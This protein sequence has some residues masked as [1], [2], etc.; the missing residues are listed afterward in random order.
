MALILTHLSPSPPIPS[1][2]LSPLSSRLNNLAMI[3]SPNS[4]RTARTTL[5]PPLML[6]KNRNY[7]IRSQL[8]YPIISPDDHWGT[9]T[10]LF[11]TGAFG[12]WYWLCF[13]HIY[14]FECVCVRLCVWFGGKGRSSFDVWD[15]LC[16]GRATTNISLCRLSLVMKETICGAKVHSFVE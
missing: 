14:A 4:Q 8:R 13:P 7:L 6:P 2:H 1:L 11:A 16:L 5:L 10:A 9:W 12:L 3:C 15:F